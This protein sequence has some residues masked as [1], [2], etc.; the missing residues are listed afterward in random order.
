MGKDVKKSEMP[1]DTVTLAINSNYKPSNNIPWFVVLIP[2]LMFELG[3]LMLLYFEIA[4]YHDDLEFY[5]NYPMLSDAPK[6]D[7]FNI[8]PCALLIIMGLVIISISL[9]LKLKNGG[10]NNGI[11]IS[12]SPSQRL[13]FLQKGVTLTSISIDQVY[14]AK[15]YSYKDK[16]GNYQP[17]TLPDNEPFLASFTNLVILYSSEGVQRV[18]E[19]SVY[20]SYKVAKAIMDAKSY[21]VLDY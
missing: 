9:F 20:E 15:P 6:I 2:G 5:A 17:T 21:S 11:A 10:V 3:G 4:W 12:Y 18:F 16:N 19:C 8:F 1:Y 7:F 14:Y 13:L